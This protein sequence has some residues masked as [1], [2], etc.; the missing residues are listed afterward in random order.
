[1]HFLV[2]KPLIIRVVLVFALL[3]LI[4]LGL[5]GSLKSALFVASSNCF[6]FVLSYSLFSWINRDFE[7]VALYQRDATESIPL[8]LLF[9]SL[10]LVIGYSM[11]PIGSVAIV[12]VMFFL[13]F[14]FLGYL[15]VQKGELMFFP[16]IP[17]EE[18]E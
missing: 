4:F 17:F 3:T 7:R 15:V 18:F 5:T 14:F 10:A 16:M 11:A 9:G 13:V 1:M 2:G 12:T 6:T 8:A